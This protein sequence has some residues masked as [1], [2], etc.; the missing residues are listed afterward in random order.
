[1]PTVSSG[2][3]IYGSNYNEIQGLVTQVLGTGLPY[4]PTGSG[5]LSYGYNQTPQST[6]VNVGDLITSTQWN[7]LSAD[8]NKIYRHQN[9]TDWPDYSTANVNQAVGQTITA[10]N[11]NSLYNAMT[12][13]VPTRLTVAAG[14]LTTTLV[15]SSTRSGSWGYSG[16]TGIQNS[17][18][19]TFASAAAL[20]Y[21]FNQGGQLRF[22]GFGPSLSGSTQDQR[23][24]EALSAFVYNLGYAHFSTLTGSYSLVYTQTGQPSPY[25]GN[26]IHVHASVSGATLNW[27][28]EYE[29]AH[30]NSYDDG[31]SGGAGFNLNILTASG[32]F[33]GTTYSSV[34]LNNTWTTGTFS[35]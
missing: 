1:M 5:N 17:G 30:S 4:G 9:N 16:D 19:I 25:S 8:V 29:D 13:L 7:A 23:W 18:S 10:A 15:G 26:Y 3:V 22:S 12:A 27:Q 28:V 33:T 34:N 11:F 24:S 35:S 6:L 32:A 20:Q 2:A 14:Q 31:V 21:F